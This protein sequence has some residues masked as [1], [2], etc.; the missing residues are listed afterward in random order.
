MRAL[1]GQGRGVAWPG[2]LTKAH[3][4]EVPDG[5]QGDR[6]EEKDPT[7]NTKGTW[8]Q[9]QKLPVGPT[10]KLRHFSTFAH[11]KLNLAALMF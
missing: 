6:R 10:D 1:R 3:E 7:P 8:E 5:H 9:G 4:P 2:E 11:M